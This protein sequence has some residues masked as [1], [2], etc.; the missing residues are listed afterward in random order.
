MALIGFAVYAV[1]LVAGLGTVA[2][3]Q[4]TVRS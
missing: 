2:F 3:V 4:S 1:C